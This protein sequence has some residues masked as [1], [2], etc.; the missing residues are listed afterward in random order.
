MKIITSPF[1]FFAVPGILCH[2]QVFSVTLFN[3][4]KLKIDFVCYPVWEGFYFPFKIFCISIVN[5][6]FLDQIFLCR[7]DHSYWDCLCAPKVQLWAVHF[8]SL[9]LSSNSQLY[10][11]LHGNLPVSRLPQRKRKRKPPANMIAVLSSVYLLFLCLSEQNQVEDLLLPTCAPMQ[12][13]GIWGAHPEMHPA[14]SGRV[15]G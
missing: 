10:S 1:L 15:F 3:S 8:F 5:E 2:L 7:R 4:F 9:Y 13:Q 6:S 14:H 12:R 11:T